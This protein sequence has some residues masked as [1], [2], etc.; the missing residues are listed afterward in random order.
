M[1]EISARMET[2]PK[3]ITAAESQDD[4]FSEISFEELLEREKKD[5][6]WYVVISEL[7]FFRMFSYWDVWW[8]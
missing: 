2:K 8:Y 1:L 5:A 3:S 6:F 4:N 7:S